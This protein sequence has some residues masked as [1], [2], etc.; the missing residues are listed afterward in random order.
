VPLSLTRAYGGEAKLIMVRPLI[1]S[2]EIM[3]IFSLLD[4]SSSTGYVMK[5][6]MTTFQ[7]EWFSMKRSY[8]PYDKSNVSARMKVSFLK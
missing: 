3:A 6:P 8:D 1:A 7:C 2:F 5:N 4:F